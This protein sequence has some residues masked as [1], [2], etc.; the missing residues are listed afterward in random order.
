MKDCTSF[1]L[2]K[3]KKKLA[4]MC[5]ID[6]NRLKGNQESINDSTMCYVCVWFEICY[7]DICRFLSS[8]GFEVWFIWEQ[9]IVR[10]WK[11]ISKLKHVVHNKTDNTDFTVKVKSYS[12]LC[13]LKL[14]DNVANNSHYNFM[15]YVILFYYGP[16]SV[17]KPAQG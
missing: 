3:G 7:L 14:L 9:M 12:V 6:I 10:T 2:R 5:V 13:R 16:T 17:Y 15:L 11:C 1:L 8:N 4:E